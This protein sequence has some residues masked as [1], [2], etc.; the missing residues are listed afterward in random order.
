MNDAQ[1]RYADV[2]KAHEKAW[3]AR[4]AVGKIMPHDKAL[5]DAFKKAYDLFEK[6]GYAKAEYDRV[7]DTPG[8]PPMP[9][10]EK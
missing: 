9:V 5:S 3:E 2:E 8:W 1:R 7:S 6:L 4:I 10:D